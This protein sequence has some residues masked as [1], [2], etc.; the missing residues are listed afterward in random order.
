MMEMQI[1]LPLIVRRLRILEEPG[2]AVTLDP[3]ITLRPENGLLA[4]LEKRAA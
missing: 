1:I 2:F 4:R 3:T